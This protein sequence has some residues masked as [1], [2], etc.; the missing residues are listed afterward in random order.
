[1]ETTATVS[2]IT[3]FHFTS[4]IENLLGILTN[5]F[6]PRYCLED[7]SAFFQELDKEEAERAIPMV[8][9]C[10]IPLSNIRKHISTYGRYLQ[11]ILK[12]SMAG[13][14]RVYLS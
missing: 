6:Y 11:Y 8:C 1:M 2:A 4:N 3:L 14:N 9:F 10:D 5:N 12:L 13:R 7:H